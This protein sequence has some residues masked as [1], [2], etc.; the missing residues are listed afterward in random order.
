VAATSPPTGV[1]PGAGCCAEEVSPPTGV[2]PGA[3]WAAGVLD[4]GGLEGVDWEVDC[5]QSVLAI[6]NP[7][8]IITLVSFILIL[9]TS[10][11]GA[12]ARQL[13]VPLRFT[14]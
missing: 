14:R 13:P 1:V 4:A 8:I 7:A 2:V 3:G 9:M 10:P 6:S 5:A 11:P 12:N